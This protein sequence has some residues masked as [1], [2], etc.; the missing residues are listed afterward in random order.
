MVQCNAKRVQL[1]AYSVRNASASFVA[2]FFSLEARRSVTQLFHSGWD[3]GAPLSMAA[4]AGAT[5]RWRRVTT[6]QCLVANGNVDALCL[7]PRIN[8]NL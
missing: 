4:E 6:P 3:I 8:T 1:D 7:F 5:R 2:F